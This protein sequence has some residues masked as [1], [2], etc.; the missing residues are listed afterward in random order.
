MKKQLHILEGIM[1][2]TFIFIAG[3]LSITFIY[4]I[5]NEKMDTSYM[6]NINFTNLT[7]TEGSKEGNIN[8]T[9]NQLNLDL[10]LE[11]EKEFYEFTLDIENNGTLGAILDEYEFLIDNEKNV[12]TYSISYIDNKEIKKGDIIPSGSISKIKVKIDY[13]EQSEKIY[14]SLK[15][16]LSLKMQYKAVL[17]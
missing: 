7:I 4:H 15:L 16:K 5:N 3:L 13:P 17:N 14:E 9:N 1:I 11:N 6:W 10:T 12:L 2:L 8:L